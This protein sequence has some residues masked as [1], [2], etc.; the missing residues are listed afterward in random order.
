MTNTA[1]NNKR[2][3]KNTLF[4]Y[5]RML[6]T[7][8]ISLYTSRIILKTLGVEDFGIYNVVGGV[9]AMLG[10]LTASLGSAAARFISYSIGEN[11]E[12][13]IKK[14]FST[15]LLIH[16]LLAFSILLI[17]ETIGLWFLE[18]KIQIPLNR[19][20]AAFWVY[21]FS[22]FSSMLS[23]LYV[24]YSA[25]IIAYEKM[26]IF[27]YFSIIDVSLK[28]GI[29]FLLSVIPFDK[30]ITYAALFVCVQLLNQIIYILYCITHFKETKSRPRFNKVIFKNIFIFMGWSVGGNLSMLANTQGLNIL[31]NLFFGPTVNAAR[32]IA[33][34][35]QGVV[36]N[37]V[38]NFQVAVNPQITKNYAAG[39]FNN[40]HK[41][42]K[43]SSKFS[44]YLMFFLSLPLM[45][46]ADLVLSWWL[47]IVP[48]H[49]TWFLRLV[50]CSTLIYTLS[51]PLCVA[52]YA[53][54]S[55]KKY[56]LID[57]CFMLMVL[58][59]SYFILKYFHL[60]PESVFGILLLVDILAQYARVKI[61][62]PVIKMDSIT[63]IKDIL[64]PILKVLF[65]APIIPIILF[66]YIP[67]N[68]FT[69]FIICII[70]VI[71]TLS[72]FYYLGCDKNEKFQIE[73]KI[74]TV[75][76]KIKL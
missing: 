19:E 60:S 47:E 45:L 54:G 7:L 66:L 72:S 9:V 43:L 21:Q 17:G 48:N 24:P 49:T 18:Q 14:T 74:I 55:L 50:L 10:F 25:T 69:F 2:I 40:L 71:S 39:D 26:S 15:L 56:Q 12:N 8:S 27:A 13:E 31:L 37:F 4:L 65:V 51:N 46:E 34:Q 63:Y 52:V 6:F 35:V 57:S 30:L 11:N 28:L 53:S 67:Q 23:I 68:L 5:F 36:R 75:I 62:L 61:V 64:Q 44:F 73:Q 41:L 38:I 22:L 76:K 20:Q 59:L 58:P 3:A 16:I 32:G 42:I 70:S 29:V 33:V 1:E